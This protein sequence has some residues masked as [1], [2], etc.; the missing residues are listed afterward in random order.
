MIG[1]LVVALKRFLF[2]L[3]LAWAAEAEPKRLVSTVP[4]L[5]EILFALGLGDR[6]AGVSEYCRYPAE[7]RSKPKTGSFLQP[8]LEAIAALRPDVVLIIRNPV[9]LGA[10]LEAMG[11]RVRE[12]DL[13]T[14]P[15]ILEAITEIGGLTGRGR[16]AGALRAGLEGRMEAVR[17]AVKIRRRVVFLVGRTPQRL[18]GMVAVGPKSY[19]EELMKLAGGD[20][21]FADAPS[22]YPKISIE[23]LLARDPDVIFEMGDSVHDGMEQKRY[24]ED[25]LGVWGR[26]TGLRAVREKRVFPLNEDIFVVPGPRFVEAAERFL[27]MISGAGR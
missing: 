18:E 9:R 3:G 7:A 11:L 15:G 10:R 21:V 22:M 20:N 2:L 19:L 5:T 16:Q 25:V 8:N 17:R 13:E 26:M 4:G 27:V 24:R 1:R 12:F 6:V 23:Q 14:M